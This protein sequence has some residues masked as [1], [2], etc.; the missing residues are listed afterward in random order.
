[1][2]TIA[3]ALFGAF[4]LCAASAAS[5]TLWLPPAG[6]DNTAVSA[7]LAAC[8]EKAGKDVARKYEQTKQLLDTGVT[9]N[10]RQAQELSVAQRRACLLQSKWLEVKLSAAQWRQYQALPENGAERIALLKQIADA[11]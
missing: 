10:T 11:D 2:R 8:Q 5:H 7:S 4:A 6:M 9:M 1:M 3:F